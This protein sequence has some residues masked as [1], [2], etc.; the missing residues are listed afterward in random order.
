MTA[1]SDDIPLELTVTNIGPVAEAKIELRPLTVFVGP[2]NAGKTY[3]A[4]LIYAMH[5]FFGITSPER[6]YGQR[7]PKPFREEGLRLVPS[8]RVPLSET[9]IETLVSWLSD[10][11]PYSEIAEQAEN[12][13]Y[14][15][16]EHVASLVRPFLRQFAHYSDSLNAG[17][18]RC[19]GI[20]KAGE[21]IRVASSGQAGF[22]LHSKTLTDQGGEDS[23]R[24]KATVAENG[25]ETVFSIPDSMPMRI[26]PGI[27][28]DHFGWHWLEYDHWYRNTVDSEHFA[29]ESLNVLAIH[30]LSQLVAPLSRPAHFLPADRAGLLHLHRAFVRSLIAGA[31]EASLHSYNQ[32]PSISGVAADF[33]EQLVA[34][35]SGRK[36]DIG[37]HH[38]VAHNV[39]HNLENQL[40]KGVIHVGFSEIDYPVFT[41]TPSGWRNDLP[42]MTASSMVS[43][44]APVVL[45]L[46]YVVQPGDLLIIEEPEAHLHPEM[47][48]LF[49]RQLVAAVQSGIRILITTHSEWILEELA[50]LVRLSELPM[51]RRKGIADEDIALSPEK[52]GAW[53]FEPRTGE[54]SIVREISLDVESA[55]FPAGFG[56]VTES[57]YNRWVEIAARIQEG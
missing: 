5:R 49:T 34:V 56:L 52:L 33:M 54:G 32:A 30:I 46:R 26:G 2:C 8:D 25:V 43:E 22:S 48:A 10:T 4:T 19:F 35:G 17:I 9:D 41:Y 18:I 11:I 15:L 50:N 31:A 24:V 6:N 53:F 57:L 12:D 51:A 47:Q 27:S 21:L 23:L 1:A 14:D 3:M 28:V 36:G 45:Y 16:D 20:G 44:L 55:T 38:V 40:L 37:N 7:R 13:S 39:A 42:L 29:I